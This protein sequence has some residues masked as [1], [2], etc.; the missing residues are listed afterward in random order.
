MSGALVAAYSAGADA[1]A[2]GPMRIYA[3]LA[4]ELVARSPV[5]L[6][7]RRV[8]D[9]G[10]GTGSASR[11]AQGA[12]VVAVDAALGM[13][14][15]DRHERPPAVAGDA[16]SLPFAAGAFDDVIAAFSLNH[17]ADPAAGARE[18]GRVARDHVLISTYAEDDDHPVK[19][20]ADRALAEAGWVPP[21]WYGAAKAAMAAW[22]TVDRAAAVL[23]GAGLEPVTVEHV[24]VS[25]PE[26]T[27]ADL[28]AWRFGMAQS[29]TFV[30]AHDGDALTARAL[31]LLGDHAG[32]LER[33]VLF[34]VARAR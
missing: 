1:W 6:A 32:P 31:E 27:A 33:S 21:S 5:P 12:H 2:R 7:G 34:I 15:A 24:R 11:A 29:S 8:L 23:R 18:A 30:A 22:G 17:L 19:G 4:E 3:R 26:L 28:V 25:F 16:Q 13:L 20:A 9:L 10:A 14:R